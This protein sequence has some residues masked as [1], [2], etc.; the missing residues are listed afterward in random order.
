MKVNIQLFL[1]SGER[2][3]IPYELKEG[4]KVEDLSKQL[5]MAIFD[6]NLVSFELGPELCFDRTFIKGCYIGPAEN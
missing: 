4:E 2:V 6:K 1:E 5:K 3:S